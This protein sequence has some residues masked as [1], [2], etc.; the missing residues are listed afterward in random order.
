M[1][2]FPEIKKWFDSSEWDIGYLTL[3]QLRICSLTPIKSIAQF[4]KGVKFVNE[5]HYRW[6]GISSGLVLIKRTPVSLNY[7]LYEE[8]SEILTNQGLEEF[9]DWTHVY[10]NFKEALILSGRGVRAR[11]SLV[12]NYKF[13]F[14]SK[15]CVIGFKE[16]IQN[17]PKIKRVAGNNFKDEFW[18]KC[19]ECDACREVCPA[20]AIHNNED[21]DWL[22]SA[23]CDI[24]LGL[25]DHPRIPSLKK[26][27]HKNVR[28]D[29]PKELVDLVTTPEKN[30]EMG[31]NNTPFMDWNAN[32]YKV[33][34]GKFFKGDKEIA[35]PICRECQ[36]QA[37]CSKWGGQYPYEE[38]YE[39]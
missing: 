37:P 14:D 6:D 18:N 22:D 10:T 27:W 21:V 3:E 39:N 13:G 2:S 28:P 34:D 11:N 5:A 16:L 36:V 12:Y 9:S 26:F 15:I 30:Q 32:G 29:I 1:L 19:I 35:V 24:F 25:S 38:E 8:A 7:L 33:I 20:N 4:A 23:A 17:P 31:N